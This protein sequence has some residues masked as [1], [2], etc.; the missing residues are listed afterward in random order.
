ME[1][2]D[3]STEKIN[4][5]LEGELFL[6][7]PAAVVID[8]LLTDSRKITHPEDLEWARSRCGVCTAGTT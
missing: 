6:Q 1:Q 8:D 3:Y 5:L 7:A 2:P 4:A